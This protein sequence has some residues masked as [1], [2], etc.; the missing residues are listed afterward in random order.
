MANASQGDTEMTPT[1]ILNRSF[2]PTFNV[3][4]V[5]GMGYDPS[6]VLKRIVS[7]TLTFRYAVDGTAVYLGEATPGA[8]Q[9]SAIW[10]VMKFDSS[11]GSIKWADGNDNFDNV[12]D[13]Y[14]S[15]TYN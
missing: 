15:L 7:D 12:W 14:A 9:A 6:G 2:D 10:R 4:A 13:D 3:L 5:E 1:N 11:T 8:S